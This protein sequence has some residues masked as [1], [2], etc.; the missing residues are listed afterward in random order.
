[1]L[2][3]EIVKVISKI[4]DMLMD[5]ASSVQTML[6]YLIK[7]LTILEEKEHLGWAT[8]EKK[9][10]KRDVPSYR[11]IRV[12]K[13]VSDSNYVFDGKVDPFKFKANCE[14]DSKAIADNLDKI[15]GLKFH[16]QVNRLDVIDSIAKIEAYA[17][18]SGLV[19]VYDLEE[20]LMLRYYYFSNIRIY[21]ASTDFVS[22]ILAVR[23]RI[24]EIIEELKAKYP[25]FTDVISMKQ[26][27]N[28]LSHNNGTILI[29]SPGSIASGSGDVN[30]NVVAQDRDKKEF[31]FW[32]NIFC[33]IVASVIAA[34]VIALIRLLKQAA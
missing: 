6:N 15:C 30:T 9:G 24:S 21:C 13:V 8:S 27:M 32:V 16:A 10:Y 31:N 14:W 26:T 12:A 34:G 17:N 20:S 19:L 29:N 18:G 5:S 33:P 11:Q 23:S 22:V 7:I 28:D 4:E 3:R 1:M 25:K 2:D